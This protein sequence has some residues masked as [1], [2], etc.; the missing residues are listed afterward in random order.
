MKKLF[1]TDGI[2]GTANIYPMT[3]EMALSLGRAIAHM[4]RGKKGKHRILV[5]KDTRLSG[6]MIEYALTA[7]I[8]SMGADV[9]LVGPLPTP[10][11]AFLTSSMRCDAG[12]V[13][14]ASH[15][16]FQDNGVKFFNA[17]GFKLKDEVEIEI[18]KLIFRNDID[19]MRPTAERI[20]KA[21]RIDDAAGRYIQFLK[22][23]F[24]A[25]YRLDGFKIVLDCAHGAGYSIAPLILEELGAKVTAINVHPNGTNINQHSGCLQPE[26]LA[27]AVVDHN[28]DIGIALD[29]DADRAVFADETGQVISGDATLMILARALHKEGCLAKNTLVATQQ[30]GLGLDKSLADLDIQVKRC[31]IGDRYVVAMMREG[32]Y[33][34]GGEQSGHIVN[35]NHTTT[36]DGMVAALQMLATMVGQE[37]RLSELAAPFE[38]YPQAFRNVSIKKRKDLASIDDV[39]TTMKKIEGELGQQGRILV[40]L[41]G[42]EPLARVMVEG[43]NQAQ[44]EGFAE[45]IASAIERNLG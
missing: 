31:Q 37:K 12:A 11:I 13:I 2:R 28:A 17:Q 44:A 40:R 6:Y 42:T 26:R 36:G 38:A 24:P 27:Q 7:G 43:P 4:Y 25:Q 45:D 41:S 10:A 19:S 22:S 8:C 5:G 35:L 39:S 34:F 21:H 1:G 23:T 32:G 18:E 9:Y 33:N 16:P 20:G 3:A 14:S 30:S 29:G 15:N